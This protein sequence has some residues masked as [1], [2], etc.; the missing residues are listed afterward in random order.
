MTTLFHRM[1]IENRLDLQDVKYLEKMEGECDETDVIKLDSSQK[2]EIAANHEWASYR[3][4]NQSVVVDTF[5][6]QFRSTV[7]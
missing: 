7:R 4:N 6:G 3:S 2:D 5:Q 1:K